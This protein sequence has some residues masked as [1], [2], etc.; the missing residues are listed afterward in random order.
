MVGSDV[1]IDKVPEVMIGEGVMIRKGFREKPSHTES[2]NLEEKRCHFQVN[3]T[4]ISIIPI[5]RTIKLTSSLFGVS[6]FFKTQSLQRIHKWGRG[7][8]HLRDLPRQQRR[9]HSSPQ[10]IYQYRRD[11]LAGLLR[12][13]QSLL[14]QSLLG[15]AGGRRDA[16]A[17]A[18]AKGVASESFNL[19]AAEMVGASGGEA[20]G[21]TSSGAEGS[22]RSKTL[23]ELVQGSAAD[24]DD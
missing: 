19:A 18:R 13:Q 24:L 1:V 9:Q 16:P 14:E 3:K 8:K 2:L 23:R 11:R 15:P 21:E 6:V 4:K 10:L 7:W 20:R 17:P 12:Q 5:S 22:D